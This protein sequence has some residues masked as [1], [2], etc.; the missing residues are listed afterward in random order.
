MINQFNNGVLALDI[1]SGKLA[2]VV[3][4]FNTDG[5]SILS[6][7]V[8]N[9]PTGFRKGHIIDFDQAYTDLKQTI[10]RICYVS[11]VSIKYLVLNIR[12]KDVDFN[13]CN[14]KIL[15]PDDIPAS[16]KEH[17][18]PFQKLAE[19][20]NIELL[21]FVPD[22]LAASSIL[23]KDSEK[24][25]SVIL[26]D[27]GRAF[28]HGVFFQNG[29]CR[30]LFEMPFGGRHISNDI[31]YGLS[32]PKREAESIKIKYSKEPE[33]IEI[34]DTRQ[35]IKEIIQARLS[36][37]FKFVNKEIEH[38]AS[39]SETLMIITGGMS[40]T[41]GLLE[42]AR[43][44]FDMPVFL[45]YTPVPGCP[46]SSGTDWENIPIGLLTMAYD[47]PVIRNKLKGQPKRAFLSAPT[48]SVPLDQILIQKNS[49]EGMPA[50]TETIEEPVQKEEPVTFQTVSHVQP[51]SP[52]IDNSISTPS[53]S[54]PSE[55]VNSFREKNGTE[56]KFQGPAP[57]HTTRPP[58]FITDREPPEL[59]KSGFVENEVISPVKVTPKSTD[60]WVGKIKTVFE[61][62]F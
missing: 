25:R 44:L 58:E 37:I 53:I 57:S 56:Y 12:T 7:G 1:G 23:L 38:L 40:K 28:T 19:K 3:G 60:N 52:V 51:A 2:G 43:S 10:A 61:D 34:A 26:L 8:N 59:S 21:G 31:A 11:N 20:L 42:V 5:I 55:P 29:Q 18:S 36:E 27:C 35:F 4:S 45:K 15:L 17:L 22:A 62:I 39:P 32:V 47:N 50:R 24:A 48:L 9:H 13:F 41:R 49:E 46:V 14:N 16:Q 33:A 54:S 6:A 30:H